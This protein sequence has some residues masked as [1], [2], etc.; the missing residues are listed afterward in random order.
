MHATPLSTGLLM[1]GLL[2]SAAA[3]AQAPP[4]RTGDGGGPRSTIT[5]PHT[6]SL[7]VT[8]PRPGNADAPFER[9]LQDRTADERRN[10]RIDT[11]ICI[12]C[13]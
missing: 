11:G 3:A 4:D 8:M 9:R 6:N 1:A 10:D 12:G 5:A 2:W 7:G 13:D